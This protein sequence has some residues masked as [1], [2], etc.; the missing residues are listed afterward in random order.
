M[1][2]IYH[3]FIWINLNQECQTGTQVVHRIATLKVS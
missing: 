1:Q 2:Q 3:I